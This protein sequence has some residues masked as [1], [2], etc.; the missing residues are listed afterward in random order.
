VSRFE[1]LLAP[2]EK[3]RA[4]GFRFDRLR[5]SFVIARGA[6]RTILGYYLGTSPALIRFAYGAS[7]K[8]VLDPNSALRFNTSHS[9]DLAIFA[10][11]LG[12]DLGVDVEQVRVVKDMQQI[13]DRF[14]CSEEA[15]EL[16]S[17]S[18]AER[19]HAF[20]LCWTRKEAYIKATGEGLSAKLDSF[21]VSLLPSQSAAMIHIGGSMESA[22]Q[23]TLH[24][25]E[26]ASTYLATLAYLDRERP[27]TIRAVA[28]PLELL[29][30]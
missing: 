6:L 11:T 10:V 7:G 17:L 25:L 9:G 13:A 23:W 16:M 3:R 2:D 26:P 8:P 4:D 19:E 12:C 21:R 28:D 24:H 1:E 5:D 14:F 18:D 22:R 15:A 20:F 30:L 27:I 29:S